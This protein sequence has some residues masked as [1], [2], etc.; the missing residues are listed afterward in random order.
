M[1]TRR[2]RRTKSIT[3]IILA[4]VLLVTTQATVQA[5]TY[6]EVVIREQNGYSFSYLRGDVKVGEYCLVGPGER[7]TPEYGT[8]LHTN[9]SYSTASG[10]AICLYKNMEKMPQPEY[11]TYARTFIV[12]NLSDFHM[13]YAPGIKWCFERIGDTQTTNILPPGYDETEPSVVIEKVPNYRVYPSV[14]YYGVDYDLDAGSW[15]HKADWIETTDGAE[16]G[17]WKSTGVQHKEDGTQ[18]DGSIWFA[19]AGLEVTVPGMG[20][21]TKEGYEFA[22]WKTVTGSAITLTPGGNYTL[23]S[24]N[25][26]YRT[27]WGME[28]ISLK[29]VWVPKHVGVQEVNQIT[30]NATAD[31][32]FVVTPSD[33]TI[34]F[35]KTAINS[36]AKGA[37]GEVRITATKVDLLELSPKA[38]ARVGDRPVYNFSVTNGNKTIAQFGGTATVTVPY[39]AKAGEDMKAIVIYDI[40]ANGDLVVVKDCVYNVKT[41]TVTFR[42]DHVSRYAVG[43]NKVSF[44]DVP[45]GAWYSEAL[46]YLAARGIIKGSG[47]GKF[48]PAKKL[49]GS[50]LLTMVQR[51]YGLES[52]LDAGNIVI[53]RDKEMTRQEMVSNLYSILEKAGQLPDSS[54]GKILMDYR[55]ANP[56]GKVTRA[57]MTQ[58]LYHLQSGI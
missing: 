39:T 21:V 1:R 31:P 36:I 6:N 49:T 54:K 24:S 7:I 12:K 25:G 30:T 23:S 13:T 3:G 9:M 10:S 45:E 5:A 52:S 57:Q 50:Q 48:G 14:C 58:L 11:Y 43:Y 35:D 17:M 53:A 41:G 32:S 20:E 4:V 33:A 44:K 15:V 37:T 22:G 28:N 18:Y 40:N 38:R 42:T 55:D 46:T 16:H 56:K 19:F 51:T 47:T 34:E 29:A 2:S 8:F 26:E 27:E